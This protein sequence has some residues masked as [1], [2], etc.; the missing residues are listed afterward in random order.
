MIR[1][2]SLNI[3]PKLEHC[4]RF[5]MQRIETNFSGSVASM[6]VRDHHDDAAQ[7]EL[8]PTLQE[9]L[10]QI[11]DQPDAHSIGDLAALT[12][13]LTSEMMLFS[14][15][16]GGA[17]TMITPPPTENNPGSADGADPAQAALHAEFIR[18]FEA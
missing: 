1:H 7:A 17:A 2:Q 15:L 12:E 9:A 14:P 10:Q 11:L 5:I 8:P 16:V 18:E 6:S 3:T 4:P 13:R